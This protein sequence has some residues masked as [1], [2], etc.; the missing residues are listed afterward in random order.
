MTPPDWFEHR[1]V[2]VRV[3][4]FTLGAV[5]L[6]AVAVFVWARKCGAK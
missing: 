3:D 6:L 1:E 4:R 2:T 5:A